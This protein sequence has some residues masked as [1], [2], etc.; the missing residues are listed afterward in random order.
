MSSLSFFA[1]PVDGDN[2]IQ[3]DMGSNNNNNNNSAIEKKRATINNLNQTPH[4]KATSSTTPP[5]QPDV[6]SPTDRVTKFIQ[7]IHNKSDEGDSDADDD[8]SITGTGTGTGTNNTQVAKLNVSVNS[9]GFDSGNDVRS[10]NANYSG[11][12]PTSTIDYTMGRTY[13]NT[14]QNEV[15]L[16]KLNYLIHLME[17]HRDER[18]DNVTEEVVLYSF[19]GVFVIF[20]VDSFVRVGKYVR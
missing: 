3:Y 18:T 11:T 5:P 1:A 19:L 6:P 13:N 7:S 10:V 4:Y 14:P 15:I 8:E 17:E 9:G 2:R 20:V 16:K 12:Q